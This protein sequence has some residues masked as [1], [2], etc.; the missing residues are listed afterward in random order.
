MKSMKAQKGQNIFEVMFFF[1]LIAS[2]SYAYIYVHINSI[3]RGQTTIKFWG[4]L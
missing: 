3:N 2:V 4:N 1:L